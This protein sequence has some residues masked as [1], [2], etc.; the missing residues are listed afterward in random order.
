MVLTTGSTQSL[1]SLSLTR[2]SSSAVVPPQPTPPPP[3]SSS[4]RHHHPHHTIIVT[5]PS[6][7]SPPQPP[8]RVRVVLLTTTKGAFWLGFKWQQP[9]AGYRGCVHRVGVIAKRGCSFG[10]G[11]H[12]HGMR[13]VAATTIKGCLLTGFS[14]KRGAYGL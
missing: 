4:P 11:S 13:W 12:H 7:L 6:P 5:T 14:R 1:R 10:G 9:W 3:P 2:P 8:Q